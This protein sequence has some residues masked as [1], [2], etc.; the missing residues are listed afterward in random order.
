MGSGNS[1]IEHTLENLMG[2]KPA[3]YLPFSRL[4]I[5]VAAKCFVFW[6]YK[7]FFGMS[8]I[9]SA[10]KIKNASFPIIIKHHDGD[11]QLSINDAR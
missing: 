4:W 5:P 2:L 11:R 8:A 1:A 3:L 6:S 7:P 9:A 10:R